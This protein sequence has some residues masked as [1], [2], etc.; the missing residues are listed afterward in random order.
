MHEYGNSKIPIFLDVNEYIRS[1][2]EC[3]RSSTVFEKTAP[4]LHPVSVPNKAMAQVAID[5]KKFPAT[6]DGFA[7]AAILIDYFTKWTEGKALKSKCAEEVA[8]FLFECMTRH[9]CFEAIIHDQGTEFCNCVA[10]ELH[11]LTGTRQKV[12]SAYHPQ[13][14][15]NL[16]I[17]STN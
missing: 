4:E 9:G 10:T 16:Q 12:T 5:L 8:E 2:H 17:K 13:G 7:Y 11:R 14:D 1:C 6:S 3:Q 15:Y